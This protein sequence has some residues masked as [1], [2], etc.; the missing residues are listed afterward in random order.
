M[1][2][3]LLRPAAASDVEQAFRWYEERR[4][5]LGN[6]FLAEVQNALE[7][8]AAHPDRYPVVYRDTRRAL[9]HRFPYGV[10]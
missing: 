3:I 8:L 1:M 4:I 5:G 9:L 2:T 10:Y 7:N 6:E